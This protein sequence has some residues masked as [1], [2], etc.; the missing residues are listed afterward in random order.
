[1][2]VTGGACDGSKRCEGFCG[3][4]SSWVVR[5]GCYWRNKVVSGVGFQRKSWRYKVGE[6][7]GW[8]WVWRKRGSSLPNGSSLLVI[9][10]ILLKSASQQLSLAS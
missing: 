3:G 4:S 1:M 2:V 5:C 8:C 7:D 9:P 10:R 6:E